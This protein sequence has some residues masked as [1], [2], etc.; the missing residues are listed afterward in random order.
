MNNT[1]LKYTPEDLLHF[2]STKNFPENTK[3]QALLTEGMNGK[4]YIISYEMDSIEE[5]EK[6]L[7]DWLNGNYQLE[8]YSRLIFI[9]P[10]AIVIDFGSYV[11]FGLI[12][13]I[14]PT[15]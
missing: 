11:Q 7:Y 9:E 5:A 1:T 8:P 15:N 2:Y 4:P 6:L 12:R 13:I 3:F 14:Y 10:D